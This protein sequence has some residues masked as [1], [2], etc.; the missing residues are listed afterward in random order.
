[1][2]KR[3]H[4]TQLNVEKLNI[5]DKEGKVKMTLFNQENIPPLIMDGK[6]ILPGHRQN[7]PISG[8]MFYNGIGEECGGLIFGSEVD[9]DGNLFSGG[10]LTFDQY[11]QDQVV[12]MYFSEDNGESSYGFSVFD[13][14]NI[15]LSKVMEQQD[16]IINSGLSD[17]EKTKE[18]DALYEGNTQRAFMG[19]DIH[20]NVSVQLWD[21]KGNPRIRMVVDENDVPRMEFLNEKGE[22]TYKLPPEE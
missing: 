1:M 22:V 19:K 12:Q 8:I 21:S 15:P 16:Q 14:P 20:G 5:V 3:D 7:D 4:Y 6:D 11:K 10:S 13:R 2:T 18:L 17:E 9:E